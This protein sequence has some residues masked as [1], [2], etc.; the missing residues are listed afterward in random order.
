MNKETRSYMFLIKYLRQIDEIKE[1]Y[2]THLHVPNGTGL[3]NKVCNLFLM[4]LNALQSYAKNMITQ[5]RSDKIQTFF[6]MIIDG[7]V[8]CIDKNIFESDD[9]LIKV[10]NAI[11]KPI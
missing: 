2:A 3:N 5:I 10:Y 1:F 9:L 7:T 4:I 11:Q 8:I 6:E